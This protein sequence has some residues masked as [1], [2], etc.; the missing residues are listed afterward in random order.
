MTLLAKEKAKALQF[1]KDE[2]EKATTWGEQAFKEWKE[3]LTVNDKD[4]LYKYSASWY[5]DINTY[6]RTGKLSDDSSRKESAVKERIKAIDAVLTKGTV[7]QDVM[8][9]R[10]ITEQQFGEESNWLR[11][12]DD[13]INEKNAAELEQKFKGKTFEQKSYMSTS[14]IQDPHQ[15]FGNRQT[16]LLEIKLPKGTHAGFLG[17]DSKLTKY[18]DQ[19]ELLVN[20]GYTFQY[21]KFSIVNPTKDGEK[22]YLKIEVTVKK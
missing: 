12:Q 7:P 6:L 15:S 11:N 10:R 1:K 5:D 20:R 9:Y 8:V 21:D 16:I 14:L 22:P 13:T 2:K 19:L 3:K 18:P 17:E 4:E